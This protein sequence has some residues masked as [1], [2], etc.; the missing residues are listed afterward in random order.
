M[1]HA[2]KRFS[3]YLTKFFKHKY[4]LGFVHCGFYLEVC[5]F[6]GEEEV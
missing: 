6:Q 3:K 1:H 5:N 4:M 2:C